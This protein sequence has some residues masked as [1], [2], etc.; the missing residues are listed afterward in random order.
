M[1]G[2]PRG[3][4]T[5]LYF[6][7]KILK[8]N[9]S[10][11]FGLYMGKSFRS[12]N[13]QQQKTYGLPLSLSLNYNFNEKSKISIDYYVREYEKNPKIR[14]LGLSYK[15]HFDFNA[16]NISILSELISINSNLISYNSEALAYMISP[17]LE[18]KNLYTT[19]IYTSEEWKSKKASSVEDYISLRLGYIFS[20]NIKLELEKLNIRNK[21]GQ[22][23][24]ENSFLARL[25]MNWSF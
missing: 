4:D 3:I 20:K 2:L 25:Y 19:F 18:Y 22:A 21:E 17:T 8:S 6:N 16:F 10:L 12:K 11:G 13:I 5:G 9:F 15:G 24:K 7:N 14:G 1:Y 23:L